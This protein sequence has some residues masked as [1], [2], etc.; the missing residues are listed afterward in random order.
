MYHTGVVPILDY[1]A[2]IWGFNNSEK[3]DSVQNRAIRWY[4]GVHKY[5]P[6][7][8]INGEMGGVNSD[9]RR[10]VEMLRYWNK[11]LVMDDNRLT[12]KVFRWDHTTKVKNW[13][14]DMYKLFEQLGEL[15]I[16]ENLHTIN[17]LTSENKLYTQFCREWENHITITPKLRT[18]SQF[19]E[20]YETEYYVQ[21]IFNR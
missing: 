10:K 9:I 19:K 3:A 16:Y 13:N 21:D 8:A 5:E 18:Y 12:K 4:L 14:G 15:N 6:N 20:S 2:G 7:L 1:C 11:L 17:L